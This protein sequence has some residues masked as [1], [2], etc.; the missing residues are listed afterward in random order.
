[1]AYSESGL[2]G[3]YSKGYVGPRVLKVTI[4]DKTASDDFWLREYWEEKREGRYN[5]NYTMILT[6][7]L[8]ET[9]LTE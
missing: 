5:Y 1:M 3:V 8:I 4:N 9:L 2:G 6:D 7:E